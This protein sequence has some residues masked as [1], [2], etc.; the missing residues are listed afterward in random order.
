MRVVKLVD[1]ICL[2][3][4]SREYNP[5]EVFINLDDSDMSDFSNQG[6]LTIQ[7]PTKITV[8][9]ILRAAV[10]QIKIKDLDNLDKLCTLYMERKL[11]VVVRQNKSMTA[12]INNLEEVYA[13]LWS[14]HNPPS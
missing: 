2:E 4:D 12:M 3:Y 7:L 11:T 5:A 14:L 10:Y 8:K 6:D 9:V 13:N 1:D